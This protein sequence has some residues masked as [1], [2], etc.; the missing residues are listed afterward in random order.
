MV[1]LVRAVLSRK[2]RPYGAWHREPSILLTAATSCFDPRVMSS[3][4]PEIATGLIPI[5]VRK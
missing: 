5:P 3:S 4:T 1:K 2:E